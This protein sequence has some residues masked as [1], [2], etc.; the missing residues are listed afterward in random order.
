M[1][2]RISSSIILYGGALALLALWILTILAVSWDSRQRNLRATERK[3]WLAV[4][5]LLP[6]FGFAL[7]LA[8][9]VF[10]RYL[11]IHS[12]SRVID[13]MARRTAVKNPYGSMAGFSGQPLARNSPETNLSPGREGQPFQRTNGKIPRPLSDLQPAST[14]AGYRTLTGLL[15]LSV[16]QGPYLGQQFI[17]NAFPVF[18]GRGQDVSIPLDG[19]LNVSRKHAEIFEAG[20]ALYI[21]DLQSTHGTRV[22]ERQVHEQLLNLGDRIQVGSTILILR[23]ME[24]GEDA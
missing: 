16:V 12:Q 11:S 10:W 24:Q 21:R 1:P 14:P 23:E 7:Y 5:I 8:T 15:G 6:L 17:L 4:S 13:E 22:N 9:R 3:A 2:D 18:I 20:G 19:D